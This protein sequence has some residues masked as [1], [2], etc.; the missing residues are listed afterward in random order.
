MTLLLVALGAAVGAPVRYLTDRFA[1]SRS[2][3]ALP[4]GTLAVNLAG[5]ALLGLLV[6]LP[7]APA[8]TALLGA[9]FC[10]TLTTYSTLSYEILE[11]ARAGT[12]ARA[13]VYLTLSVLAGLGA[14][15]LGLLAGAAF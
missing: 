4:W 10:G 5:S 1:R 14:A 8:W 9:G 12:R 7:A 11:L 2:G 13:A 6:G 15:A 3:S